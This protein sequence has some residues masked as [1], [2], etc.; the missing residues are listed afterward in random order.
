MRAENNKIRELMG[1]MGISPRPTV[2]HWLNQKNDQGRREM[3]EALISWDRYT[4]GE[5][6]R[7]KMRRKWRRG[8]RGHEEN[9]S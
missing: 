7:R 2:P 8:W 1:G 4:V 5:R 9:E 3:Q 6:T